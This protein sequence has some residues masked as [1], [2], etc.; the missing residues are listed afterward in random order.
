MKLWRDD[1]RAWREILPGVFNRVLYEKDFGSIS[2]VR[3]KKGASY[4]L[5]KGAVNHQGILVKGSGILDIGTRKIA[6]REGDAYFINPLDD[7]GFTNT[8]DGDSIM[9]EIFVPP[10][11][12]SEAVAQPA[13]Q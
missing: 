2:M 13:E 12:G 9:I 1:A 11:S 7:H 6:L 5:H 10:R 3:F 8:S 4:P